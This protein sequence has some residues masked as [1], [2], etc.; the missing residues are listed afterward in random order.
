[1]MTVMAHSIATGTFPCAPIVA[2]GWLNGMDFDIH[3]DKHDDF[4]EGRKCTH[5]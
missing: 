4:G 1:M 2:W 3:Q 5:S